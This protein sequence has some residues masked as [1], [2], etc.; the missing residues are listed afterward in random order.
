VSA[1]GDDG[2]PR[3]LVADGAGLRLVA[4]LPLASYADVAPRA[5]DDVWLAG[6]LAAARDGVRAWPEGEGVLVHFDG[7]R[8]T[9]H[10][11][12]DGALLAV[13]AVGPG[14]AWAVGMGG[15]LVHAK[16][17]AV[18]AFHLASTSG[19]RLEPALRAV[20][21][22]A[23]DDVWI[24]G[25]AAT[26]LHWDGRSLRRVDAALAG[27]DGALTS[28]IAPAAAPGWVVGPGGVWRIAGV[29]GAGARP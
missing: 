14:E 12:P 20:S 16:A 17:G 22:R 11:A 26:L 27:P 5:E 4:G 7:K 24:A 6:G 8:F 9:R 25:D 28:V 21:A 3:A 18:E 23:P 13:V 19:D 2:D 15:G 29:A 1:S 10:R